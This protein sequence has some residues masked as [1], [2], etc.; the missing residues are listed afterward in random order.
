MDEATARALMEA[1]L[2]LNAALGE[3]DTVI[4]KMTDLEEK[5]VWI[6]K[7]GDL[8][9]LQY[10]GFVQPIIREFPDMGRSWA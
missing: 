3:F 4:T 10:E 1:V 2:S 8:L 7:L 5:Q 6:Q 9:R